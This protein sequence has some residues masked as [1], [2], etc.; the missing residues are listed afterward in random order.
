VLKESLR[1]KKLTGTA[2]NEQLAND[3]MNDSITYTPVGRECFGALV[4]YPPIK[5]KKTSLVIC[6]Y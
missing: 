5:T 3:Y 2:S 4:V 1:I 6:D